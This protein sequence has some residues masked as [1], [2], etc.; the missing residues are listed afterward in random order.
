V[1]QRS[2]HCHACRKNVAGNPQVCPFCAAPNPTL[3]YDLTIRM[4]A[5]FVVLIILASSATMLL[6]DKSATRRY[7]I[8][9][10]YPVVKAGPI[11]RT[12]KVLDTA[13]QNRVVTE[14]QAEAL[15]CLMLDRDKISKVTL[16]DKDPD[17][18]KVHVIAPNQ[19]ADAFEG[20]TDVQTLGSDPVVAN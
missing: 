18:L 14:D 6:R 3:S 11:C 7:K 8:G 19:R 12:P 16:L 4:V 2:S 20:W 1:A 5:T 9:L 17:V 15:G 10:T 13:N